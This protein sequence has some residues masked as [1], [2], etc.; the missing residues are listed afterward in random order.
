MGRKRVLDDV[1][2]S[3]VCAL[4][5]AGMSLTKVAYY[6]GCARR[7]IQLER[8]ADDEFDRRLRRA[9]MARDLNPREAMRRFAATHWRAAAWMLEREERQQAAQAQAT[10]DAQFTAS[11]L[12]DLA[13]NLKRLLRDS[14]Y[15]PIVTPLLIVRIERLFAEAMR[16]A[17][18]NAGGKALPAPARAESN[19][20]ERAPN[21]CAPAQVNF[22]AA[23]R[24]TVIRGRYTEKN[25]PIDGPK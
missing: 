23:S 21:S 15:D 11:Q 1:K 25:L 19:A 8:Q 10:S 16:T 9:A 20:A 2:K 7:T 4:V 14:L 17:D 18:A 5:T 12:Q 3:E 6:V 13:D 24:S 22:P